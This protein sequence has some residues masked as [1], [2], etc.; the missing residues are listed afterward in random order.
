MKKLSS[1]ALALTTA[2]VL[3]AC[4][5]GGSD[6]DTASNAASPVTAA[7]SSNLAAL[8]AVAI[9]TD[10][11]TES[12]DVVASI[13]DTWRLVI[14]KTTGAYTLTPNNSQYGLAAESG[15]LA[16]TTSGDFVTYVLANKVSLTQDTRTGAL[17]GS[18]T[19]GSQSAQVTGTPYQVS[20]ASKLAGIYNFMGTTRDKI[21]GG[22]R[23]FHAGQV[24]ISSNGASA[25]FCVGGLVDSSGNCTDA[26][27]TDGKSPEKAVLALG[28]ETGSNGGFYKMTVTGSDNQ[29]HDFG[30]LM[31]Q[32]GNLGTVL[33][34]DRYGNGDNG[35][36]STVRLGNFYA[37]KSQTLKGSELDGKWKCQTTNG[38]ANLTVNGTTN[39]I[40][41]PTETPSSWTETLSYNKVNAANG[42]LISI[43]GFAVSTYEGQGVLVLPLSASLFAVE[44]DSVHGVVMCAKSSV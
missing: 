1:F 43:P 21:G 25:T 22:N 14:N 23:N 39:A 9:S 44:A 26:D 29:S 4:G 19:V 28:K 35:V 40:V 10:S 15:T 30:N 27:T 31:V 37:V 3:T 42:A 6:S 20:D 33:L 7:A 13:G 17:V 2:L 38:A 34:V 8:S 11:A 5:G 36:S 24:L 41:N 32:N 16:R 12:F 18:M